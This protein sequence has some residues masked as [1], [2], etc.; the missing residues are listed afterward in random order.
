MLEDCHFP[1]VEASCSREPTTASS[2]VLPP[3]GTNKGA[4]AALPCPP[5]PKTA[6][7]HGPDRAGGQAPALREAAP[8]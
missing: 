4:A 8:G 6:A 2:H 1:S 3:R 5:S 7:S